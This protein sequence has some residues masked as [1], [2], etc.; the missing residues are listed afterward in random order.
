MI[1]FLFVS[2]LSSTLFFGASSISPMPDPSAV[3]CKF[4]G[5]DTEIRK[6]LQGN[7]YAVCIFP[8]GSECDTWAFYRGSCGQPYSYCSKKGCETKSITEVNDSHS[9]TYCAC[10]CLDSLGNEKVIPIDQFM[11]QN[12]DTL[13]KSNPGWVGKGK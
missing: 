2:I 10:A 6:D 13:I 4:L 11:E 9:I 12:G 8:D 5:Y 1:H 3:Y 7:E